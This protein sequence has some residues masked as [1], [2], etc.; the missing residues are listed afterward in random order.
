MEEKNAQESIKTRIWYLQKTKLELALAVAME[1]LVDKRSDKK[2]EEDKKT[3]NDY[4]TIIL[5]IKKEDV[6]KND[7]NQPKTDKNRQ[8]T[9]TKA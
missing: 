5:K 1:F 6:N 7:E 2:V 8:N 3:E 9:Q 4:E